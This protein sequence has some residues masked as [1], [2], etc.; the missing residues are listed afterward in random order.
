MKLNPSVVRASVIA[1]VVLGAAL[2]LYDA[3]ERRVWL[4][5]VPKR[6]VGSWSLVREY[7]SSPYGISQFEL[8]SNMVRIKFEHDDE[9]RWT[10]MPI[11]KVS[12]TTRNDPGYGYVVLFAGKANSDYIADN[13]Y[14]VDFSP[15]E[16]ITISQIVSTGWGDDELFCAGDFVRLH[17]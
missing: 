9:V 8:H 1:V 3:R 7:A 15:K 2:W 10:S 14:R 13:R 5:S 12:L 4:D 17:Q 6:L 16:L 11:L